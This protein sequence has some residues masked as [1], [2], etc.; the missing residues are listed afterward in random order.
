MP[1]GVFIGSKVHFFVKFCQNIGVL[2][3]L[4]RLKWSDLLVP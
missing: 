4:K 2:V 3:C 1:L